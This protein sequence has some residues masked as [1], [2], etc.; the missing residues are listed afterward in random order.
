MRTIEFINS[1]GETVQWGINFT[2]MAAAKRGLAYVKAN[3]SKQAKIV[4]L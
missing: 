1:K 3:F 4:E 2:S